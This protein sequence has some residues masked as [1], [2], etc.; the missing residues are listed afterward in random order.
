MLVA[1]AVLILVRLM[2]VSTL[3]LTL[4]LAA[5]AFLTAALAAA[6]VG[7]ATA[8][9]IA[10]LGILLAAFGWRALAAFLRLPGLGICGSFLRGSGLWPWFRGFARGDRTA[11][12]NAADAARRFLA[13]R[14]W[15]FD[16]W[17]GRLGRGFRGGGLFRTRGSRRLGNDGLFLGSWNGRGRSWFVE[18]KFRVG[19]IRLGCGFPGNLLGGC[20]FGRGLLRDGLLGRPLACG[21][22]FT[23]S[24][25]GCLRHGVLVGMVAHPESI[26]K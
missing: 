6:F 12:G 8:L 1:V 17:S 20:L 11:A 16:W 21:W 10:G 25:G 13:G 23:V 2:G 26:E 24:A 3:A 9:A 15:D 19:K 14:L 7:L 22:C 18:R 5:L 4:L